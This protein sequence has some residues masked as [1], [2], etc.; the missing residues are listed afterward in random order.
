MPSCGTCHLLGHGSYAL[1]V[2]AFHNV[3]SW[4]SEIVYQSYG[5]VLLQIKDVGYL[6]VYDNVLDPEMISS[7]RT[8]VIDIVSPLESYKGVAEV[9]V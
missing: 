7:I 9:P 4:G 1:F 6:M 2:V 3:L 5:T 8:F